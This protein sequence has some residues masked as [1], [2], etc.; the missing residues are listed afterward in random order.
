MNFETIICVSIG[1][2][3][4]MCIC[5]ELNIF[6]PNGHGENTYLW[7]VPMELDPS[8]KPPCAACNTQTDSGRW[9][10]LS[11]IASF[12]GVKWRKYFV[13]AALGSGLYIILK[14]VMNVRSNRG[15]FIMITL[16]V[17][18]AHLA[19]N[20]FTSFHGVDAAHRYLTHKMIRE[21]HR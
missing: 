8:A 14:D 17:F 2:V 12:E 16:L 1:I 15:S 13:S 7:Q 3:V 20:N 9:H 5:M 21:L 19:A 4:V 11:S 6:F 10:C 18:F